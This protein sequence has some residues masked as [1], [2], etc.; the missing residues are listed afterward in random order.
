MKFAQLRVMSTSLGNKSF[1]AADA[2]QFEINPT[3]TKLDRYL[4]KSA[5]MLILNSLI[6]HG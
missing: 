2:G 3:V 5:K 4:Y 6:A 1:G